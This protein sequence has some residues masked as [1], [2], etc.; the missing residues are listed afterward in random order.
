LILRACVTCGKPS[1]SGYCDEHKP[2]PWQT[3]RRR[4]RRR[5]SGW[6]EQRRRQRVLAKFMGACHWC[7]RKGATEVD[8]VVPLA[9]GGSDTEQN[10]APIH[11]DCHREK[12]AAEARRARA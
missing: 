4:E 1:R 3:S 11:S 5:V 7:G 2:K 10:L 12:T 9:E 6:E 8:H